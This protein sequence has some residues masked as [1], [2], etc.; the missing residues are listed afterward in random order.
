MHP[1][2]IEKNFLIS[3]P[4]SPPVGWEQIKEDPPNATPLADDLINALRKLEIQAEFSRTKVEGRKGVEVLIDPEEGHGIG[5]YVEDCDPVD[6]DE[7]MDVYGGDDDEDRN[8]EGWAYGE[9]SRYRMG[10][11]GALPSGWK[12]MPTSRP[13]MSI[14]V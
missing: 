12:P 10:P 14:P 9:T 6:E 11:G 8:G 5:V 3:P 1:P 2:A 4:G 7:V 13:P